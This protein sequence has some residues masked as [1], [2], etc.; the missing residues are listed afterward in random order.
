MDGKRGSWHKRR[1]G[2]LRDA[3]SQRVPGI[4]EHADSDGGREGWNGGEQ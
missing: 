4:M 3:G 2:W 1:N